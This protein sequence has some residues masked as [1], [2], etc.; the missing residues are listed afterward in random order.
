MP[1]AGQIIRA[2]DFD[3]YASDYE[4]TDET[5]FNSTSYTLGGTTVGTTFTAPTSGRVMVTVGAR[6][7]LNSA[8]AVNVLVTAEVRTGGVIG[9]GTQVHPATDD[10]AV[11]IGQTANDRVG[12]DRTI[13][14]TGLTPGDTYN[15]SVWHR[16]ATS[17][18]SA[19]SIFARTVTVVPI[20]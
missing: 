5:N 4:S 17:A 9:S 2:A 13:P 11:E 3:G 8:T 14:I 16:N 19:A 20:P 6:V 12:S 10:Y 15:V 18:A 1:R 7:R